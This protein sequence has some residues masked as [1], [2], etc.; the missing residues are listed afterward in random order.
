M[1]AMQGGFEVEIP[2]DAGSVLDQLEHLIGAPPEAVV[3]RDRST[4][5]HELVELSRRRGVPLIDTYS[6]PQM[7]APPGPA[8]QIVR[9]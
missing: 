5:S 6:Y 1:L 2:L 3:V 7:A 9:R 4:Q 8:E